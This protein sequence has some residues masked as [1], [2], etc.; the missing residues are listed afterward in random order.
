MIGSYFFRSK[1][2]AFLV[3]IE[4]TINAADCSRKREAP[5][6]PILVEVVK[7]HFFDNEMP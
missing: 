7:P 5:L 2:L 6:R 3:R 1:P 4:Y